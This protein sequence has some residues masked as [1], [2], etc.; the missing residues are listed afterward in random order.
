[1]IYLPLT[2]AQIRTHKP[3]RW[4]NFAKLGASLLSPPYTHHTSHTH[5][6]HTHTPHTNATEGGA[7]VIAAAIVA[8]TNTETA[9]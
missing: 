7:T 1:M 4:F 5:T 3:P 8:I 6:T 9:D 2:H